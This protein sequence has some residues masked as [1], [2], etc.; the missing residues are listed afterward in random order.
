MPKK[1]CCCG[2]KPPLE[3]TFCCNPLFF[4]DFITLYGDD[5]S[6][7]AEVS[8]LD[9]IALYIPRSSFNTSDSTVLTTLE[10][11]SAGCRC[12]CEQEEESCNNTASG[13]QTSPLF[14]LEKNKS[15]RKN[16]LNGIKK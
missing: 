1:Q 9:W 13:S 2:V 8:P 5:M 7:H 12:C 11:T 10:S 6:T 4:T 14:G 15:S 3:T 16:F